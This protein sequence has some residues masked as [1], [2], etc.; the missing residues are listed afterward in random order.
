MKKLIS[1]VF[2]ITICFILNSFAQETRNNQYFNQNELKGIVKDA[3]GNALEKVRIFYPTFDETDSKGEFKL[4]NFDSKFLF[5]AKDTYKPKFIKIQKQKDLEIILEKENDSE[6]LFIKQCSEKYINNK[7]FFD[8]LVSVPK[9][10]KRKK[11]K[12]I[13]YGYFRIYDKKNKSDEILEGISGPNASGVLP[14]KK[15]ILNTEKIN[16]RSIYNSTGDIGFDLFGITKERIY[17][18][19]I[20][21]FFDHFYY[22]VKSESYKEKFDKIINDSCSNLARYKN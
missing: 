12:D 6:K 21:V 16:V 20:T 4:E 5:L 3:Q 19:K 9:G 17:W 22:D 7:G 2:V 13:D 15:L 8:V 10:F 1:F 18:R 11:S 14:D